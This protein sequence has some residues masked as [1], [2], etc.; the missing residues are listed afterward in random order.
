MM[1][2]FQSECE[3]QAL[4]K[5]RRIL[6]TYANRIGQRS[7][8]TIITLE[9]LNAVKK[10]LKKSASKNTA[11]SCHWVHGRSRT[12]LLWIVGNRNKFNNEGIIPVNSTQKDILHLNYENSWKFLQLIKCLVAIAALFHDFGKASKLF[13]E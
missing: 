4:K 1:V 11:V 5:T 2:I 10:H 7:W 12:E 3:K 6:D 13:I 9:G 8:Q